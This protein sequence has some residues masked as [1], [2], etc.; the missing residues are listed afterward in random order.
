M[1]RVKLLSGEEAE[2][3]FVS[4]LDDCVQLDTP[5]DLQVLIVAFSEVS[6]DQQFELYA[7]ACDGRVAEARGYGTDNDLSTGWKSH[8]QKSAFLQN[9]TRKLHP[10]L[11]TLVDCE[12]DATHAFSSSQVEALLQLPM[13]PVAPDERPRDVGGRTPLTISSQNGHVD[14]AQLLLE[15]GA[16]PETALMIAALS[17]H[18]PVVRLL[19]Q[20]GAHLDMIVDFRGHT[21]LMRAADGGHAAIVRMLLEA[22]AEK[23]LRNIYGRT[24]LMMATDPEAPPRSP[25]SCRE[26]LERFLS[27]LYLSL[28]D[29]V[30]QPELSEL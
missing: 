14:V 21:A 9:N 13:D 25:Q 24:A 17:G 6:E 19:L 7:A 4:T 10:K 16:C 18:A 26:T 20:A 23:D 1:L 3:A 12:M 5:M 2:A 28:Q 8:L 27:D 15:A 29:V 22:G 30:L 11:P